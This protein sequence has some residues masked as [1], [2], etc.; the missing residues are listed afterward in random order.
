MFFVHFSRHL[1]SK[2]F[3]NL[4]DPFVFESEKLQRF[5]ILWKSFV[6]KRHLMLSS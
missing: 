4:K 2:F 1:G 5:S 6:K 3:E